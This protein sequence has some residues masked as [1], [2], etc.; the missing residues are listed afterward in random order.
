M[1][2]LK[3]CYSL[4]SDFI[5]LRHGQCPENEAQWRRRVSLQKYSIGGRGRGRVDTG[6]LW[7]AQLSWNL[8]CR[9]GLN[10]DPLASDGS[11]RIKSVSR[12][13][14]LRNVV[15]M[16]AWNKCILSHLRCWHCVP[17]PCT[18]TRQVPWSALSVLWFILIQTMIMSF[19]WPGLP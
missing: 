13:T 19:C 8:L 11:A 4:K 15:L 9:A 2:S 5:L 14:Q 18:H 16:S 12:H 3:S 10:S 7:I 17:G 1:C 6:F